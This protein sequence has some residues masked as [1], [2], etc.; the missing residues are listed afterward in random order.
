MERGTGTVLVLT[1]LLLMEEATVREKERRR[2]TASP[3]TAQ[4]S[5]LLFPCCCVHQ[6]MKVEAI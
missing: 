1:P 5:V 6:M 3:D 4:V 2:K